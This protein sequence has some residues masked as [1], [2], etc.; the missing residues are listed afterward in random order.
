MP[1]LNGVSPPKV[2]F[3]TNS[4]HP[5]THPL[6]E[7]S[8]HRGI[9]SC[10][11]KAKSK[12]FWRCRLG[13]GRPATSTVSDFVL[14]RFTEDEEKKREAVYE[15][16][17]E[18]FRTHFVATHRGLEGADELADGSSSSSESDSDDGE[19]HRPHIMTAPPS[20]QHKTR[21]V[22]GTTLG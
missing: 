19:V 16:A 9:L 22:E 20:F 6:H 11:E 1:E 7:Y 14:E 8:G 5:H 17:W 12:D 21:Q 10:Y 3:N 4:N 13:I 2:C 15:K 18:Q